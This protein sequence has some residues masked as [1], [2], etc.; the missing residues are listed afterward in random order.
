MYV[1]NRSNIRKLLEKE[2][3]SFSSCDLPLSRHFLFYRGIGF[4]V[5]P[6]RDSTKLLTCRPCAREKTQVYSGRVFNRRLTTRTK[7]L[8]L[9]IND[10]SKENLLIFLKYPDYYTNKSSKYS[11][12]LNSIKFHKF[13]L[14][15]LQTR[16]HESHKIIH[17]SLQLILCLHQMKKYHYLILACSK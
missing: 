1:Q 8:L 15:H 12:E 17:D 16:I 9:P 13:A 6:Q 10:K 14:L 3:N 2:K 4:G 11:R 7:K 5:Y